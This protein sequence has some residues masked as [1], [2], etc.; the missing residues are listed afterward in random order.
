MFDFFE[1]FGFQLTSSETFQV[2]LFWISATLYKKY[3]VLIISM[4]TAPQIWMILCCC[5]D[6][7]LIGNFSFLLLLFFFCTPVFFFLIERLIICQ[8]WSSLINMTSPIN[9]NFQYYISQNFFASA[10]SSAPLFCICT[11]SLKKVLV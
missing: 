7:Y 8:T 6:F 5:N 2:Y 4:R 1:L 11:I 3:Y 10:L 9:Y